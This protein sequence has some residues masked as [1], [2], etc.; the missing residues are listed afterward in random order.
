MPLPTTL[1]T[2][3]GTITLG[4][5]LTSLTVVHDGHE[6]I[7]TDATVVALFFRRWG[8]VTYV[9]AVAVAYS[10]VYVGAHWPSD[11]PPSAALGVLVGLAV[12]FGV[13]VA[14]GYASHVEAGMPVGHL[15]LLCSPI[16]LVRHR[17]L[18]SEW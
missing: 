7:F 17:G 6:H 15:R 11:I 13:G 8:M 9:L 16:H 5:P 14:D 18:L 3:P 10:R 4:V 1:V 12:A 2:T